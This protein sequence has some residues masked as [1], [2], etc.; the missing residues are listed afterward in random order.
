MVPGS[1]VDQ[2]FVRED[3]PEL[4]MQSHYALKVLYNI[5]KMLI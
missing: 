4:F 3:C 2:K 5:Q 1:V